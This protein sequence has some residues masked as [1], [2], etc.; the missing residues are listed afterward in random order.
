M[1]VLQSHSLDEITEK[2]KKVREISWTQGRGQKKQRG[3]RSGE[4]GSGH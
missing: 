3:G 2:E 4:E 1:D